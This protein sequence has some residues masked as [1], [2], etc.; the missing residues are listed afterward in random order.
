MIFVILEFNNIFIGDIKNHYHI[1]IFYVFKKLAIYKVCKERVRS[2]MCGI[3]NSIK[4]MVIIF[5]AIYQLFNYNYYTQSNIIISK[6]EKQNII[7]NYNQ[8]IFINFI[9]FK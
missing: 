7:T 3:V 2:S 4:I 6:L 5:C 8:W 9:I 1:Y